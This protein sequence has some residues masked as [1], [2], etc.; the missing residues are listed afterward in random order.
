MS[1]TNF[2]FSMCVC[3]YLLPSKILWLLWQLV[4]TTSG[5]CG[6]RVLP[7]IPLVAATSC[8]SNQGSLDGSRYTH[9]YCVMIVSAG[10]N[11]SLH[12]LLPASHML[13]K[14]KD[15]PINPPVSAPPPGPHASVFVQKSSSCSSAL[16]Q[17]RGSQHKQQK[18]D[19]SLISLQAGGA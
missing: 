8:H 16:Q 7:H 19:S 18:Q 6:Q 15:T 3:V 14:C 9:T 2:L 13:I 11:Q 10:C 4:A 12:W 5:L 17:H 1:T